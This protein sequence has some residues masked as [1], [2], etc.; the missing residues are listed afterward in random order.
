M[1]ITSVTLYCVS[2]VYSDI[3]RVYTNNKNIR[4][5]LQYRINRT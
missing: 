3:R 4:M 5:L 2:Q 1:A